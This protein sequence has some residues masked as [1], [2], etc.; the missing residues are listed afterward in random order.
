VAG[1]PF[2]VRKL[3]VR[4]SD[5]RSIDV[6]ERWAVI[7]ARSG[8]VRKLDLPDLEDAAQVRDAL[9][10]AQQRLAAH[11]ATINTAE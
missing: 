3:D 8:R 9:R 7:T 6:G 1:R 10:L 5:L 4:W 2:K 11:G